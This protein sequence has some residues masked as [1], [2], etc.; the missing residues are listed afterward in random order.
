MNNS[1]SKTSLDPEIAELVAKARSAQAIFESFS[2]EQ[3]DGVVRDIGKYVYDNAEL[4][5]RMA[6]DETGI[7]NYEDKVLKK[8]GLT[9]KS[10]T[11]KRCNARCHWPDMRRM[12]CEV[13]HDGERVSAGSGQ[14]RN[15]DCPRRH[16]T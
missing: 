11:T 7:G 1:Q 2:Q 4:L 14:K 3:V 15:T 10:R 9:K 6:V 16:R 13:F 12:K 8:K 5:S